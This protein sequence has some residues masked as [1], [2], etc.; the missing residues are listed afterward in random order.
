MRTNERM[1]IEETCAVVKY[2]V[3]EAKSRIEEIHHDTQ[4]QLENIVRLLGWA[5]VLV[6]GH[7]AVLV[8]IIL[9]LVLMAD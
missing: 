6:S 9:M 1:T 7:L 2:K 8:A 3:Q 4:Q 5:V